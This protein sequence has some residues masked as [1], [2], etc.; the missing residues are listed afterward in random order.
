VFTQFLIYGVTPTNDR[1]A[2]IGSAV[3]FVVGQNDEKPAGF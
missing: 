2:V 1:I 3:E